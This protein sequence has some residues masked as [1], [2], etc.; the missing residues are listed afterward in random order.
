MS[1]KKYLILIAGPTASG[2]TALS[3]DL[4]NH[5]DA[6]ILSCDSRQFYIEMN[7][8]TAKPDEKELASAKHHFINSLSV[9]QNYN[10]GNFERDAIELLNKYFIHNNV[11]IMV[12]GSGL[13][14]K[15]VCD[16]VDYFPPVDEAF[17]IELNL[18]LQ[19]EGLQV[20][21]EE[22]KKSDPVYYEKVDLSNP[23]RLIRALEICRSTGKPFSSFLN[24]SKISRPFKIIK[25]G[26]DYERPAL[27]ERINRRVGL[28]MK[29][30]LLQEVKSLLPLRQLNALQ[31]VGYRE[32]FDY[33]DGEISLDDAVNLV[34][35]NTRR[36]AKRQMT[37][38][39]KD[40]DMLWLNADSKVSDAVDL[41]DSQMKT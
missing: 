28:M 33:F 2:K 13:Y 27:Y 10:A 9:H 8:G 31:T 14:I 17:R 26:I 19:S 35:R 34:K 30:G 36:Y 4:A 12:G 16:G 7:I 37:W 18:Q 29:A 24:K 22:L 11:A 1:A 21:Q 5:F 39:R 41:I 23:Q 15:A 38:F 3:V 40:K 20:L 32:F 6:E 25:I